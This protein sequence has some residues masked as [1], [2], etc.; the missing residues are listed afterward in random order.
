MLKLDKHQERKREQNEQ[1]QKKTK[2]QKV[3]LTQQESI[4][5]GY[6]YRCHYTLARE[7]YINV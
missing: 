7:I 6:R 2:K 3:L 5:R 4:C 1:Q